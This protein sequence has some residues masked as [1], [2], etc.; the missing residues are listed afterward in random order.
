[1]IVPVQRGANLGWG[2]TGGRGRIK[3]KSRGCVGRGAFG[4]SGSAF[5]CGTLTPCPGVKYILGLG[6]DLGLP[7]FIGYRFNAVGSRVDGVRVIVSS[8]K[9]GLEPN[10]RFNPVDSVSKRR[11]TRS[12]RSTHRCAHRFCSKKTQKK[13][14]RESKALGVKGP[15]GQRRTCGVR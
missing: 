12:T 10:I 3:R 4:S 7:R 1:M 8:V 6:W 14:T 2:R 5:S 13:W 11:T 15:R 9:C